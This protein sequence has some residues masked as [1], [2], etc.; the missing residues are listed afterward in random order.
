M[1][2]DLASIVIG[3]GIIAVAGAFLFLYG[4][5]YEWPIG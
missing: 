1:G 3:F 5:R 4:R 2:V